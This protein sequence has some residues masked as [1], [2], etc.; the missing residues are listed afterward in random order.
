M[1]AAIKV[2]PPIK[3]GFPNQQLLTR[4]VHFDHMATGPPG[5]IPSLLRMQPFLWA[6]IAC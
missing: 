3:S 1:L 6:L 5:C 4:V 2:E